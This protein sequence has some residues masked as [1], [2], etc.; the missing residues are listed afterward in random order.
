M[1]RQFAPARRRRK[2]DAMSAI[3]AT[4]TAA[5]TTGGA[6]IAF[7]APKTVVRMLGSGILTFSEIGINA[8]D[9]MTLVT[10]I[11]VVSTDAATLGATALPDP[12]AELSYPWL[13]WESHTISANVATGAANDFGTAG[14]A[15]YSFDI[16]SQRKISPNQSLVYFA[17]YV[18]VSGLPSVQW[19]CGPTR[20]LL[21]EP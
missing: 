14:T 15:R 2:W 19:I 6:Q 16:R 21:L 4:L 5:G 7:S 12:A 10:A 20:V 8:G 13:Y 3:A 18:D 9:Q 1:A 11:G 17:E